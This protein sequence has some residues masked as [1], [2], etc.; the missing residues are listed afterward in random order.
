MYS[1]PFS[2]TLLPVGIGSTL[3]SDCDILTSA[4]RPHVVPLPN[5]EKVLQQSKV[6]LNKYPIKTRMPEKAFGRANKT[7][8]TPENKTKLTPEPL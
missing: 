8:Q 3:V 2:G 4:S 7:K 5:V 6:R 1:S